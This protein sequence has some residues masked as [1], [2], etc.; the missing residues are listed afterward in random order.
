MATTSIGSTGVTFPD[1]SLQAS[2]AVT[3]VNGKGPG[4]VQSVLVSGTAVASTSGTNILFSS[5]PSWVK[6]ITV[7]F[8]GVSLSGSNQML[9]QV[10][11]GSITSTGY[12]GCAQQLNPAPAIG[13]N[14]FT[15]GFGIQINDPSIVLYGHMVLTNVSGNT[16]VASH[17]MS[18][19]GF[20]YMNIGGGNVTLSGA[21]DRVNITGGGNTFD[22][23]TINIL[24][25]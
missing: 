12:L 14:Q 5:I 11:S 22:A 7:M 9:V 21:L 4:I 3:T 24:Y 15:T 23:G 2:A 6:R 13:A 10:G 18:N 19:T 20:N 1:A 25:E 8:S 17:V 16:W